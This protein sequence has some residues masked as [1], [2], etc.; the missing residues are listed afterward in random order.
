LTGSLRRAQ[1]EER[2]DK[3][4]A[5]GGWHI[6][7]REHDDEKG[8]EVERRVL[9]D[10]DG[11]SFDEILR[12]AGRLRNHEHVPENLGMCGKD[13]PEDAKLDVFRL[14]HHVSVIEPG[15]TTNDWGRGVGRGILHSSGA[16][17]RRI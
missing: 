1:S 5:A 12:V 3:R 4:R 8:F 14:K 17:S 9:H 15:R 13:T 2:Y 7:S 16:L 6:Q 10:D 11:T